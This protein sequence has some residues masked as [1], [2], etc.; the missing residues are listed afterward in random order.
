MLREIID[1][2]RCAKYYKEICY[3]KY[4]GNTLSEIIKEIFWAK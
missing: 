3:A 4:N 2:I 1:D